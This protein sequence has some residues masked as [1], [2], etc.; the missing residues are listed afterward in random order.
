MIGNQKGMTVVELLGALLLVSLVAIIA[1]TA[2]SIGLQHTALETGKTKLQQEA[3]T[4]V[5]ILSAEHRRTEYYYLKFHEGHLQI[6]ACSIEESNVKCQGFRNVS[7][8]S[9]EFA[10]T[11]NEIEFANL[12]SSKKIEPKKAHV[13]FHLK[14]SDPL[15]P[16]NSV[17]VSTTLTRILT[18]QK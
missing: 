13:D 12:D 1:W 16:S 18:S 7:T 4:I 5:S 6:D 17:S 14:V 11:V 9:Y 10:G 3:N 15:N 2:L 8:E